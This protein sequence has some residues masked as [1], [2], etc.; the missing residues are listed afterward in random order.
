MPALLQD[1][2]HSTRM[3]I[4]NPGLSLICIITLGLGIS[5]PT[6]M[7]SIING[8]LYQPLPFEESKNLL[9]L[10]RNNPENNSSRMSV[11]YHDFVDWREQQRTLEDI[12]GSYSGTVNLNNE[13]E[14]PVRYQGAFITPGSFP[15]L[16]VDPVLGRTFAEDE[17][18]PDAPQVILLGYDVWQNRFGGESDA[19]GR[20]IRVNGATTTIIGVMPEGF[21]YP[22]D[23]EV[24][25]PIRYDP[26]TL[27]H[28]G[29]TQLQVFG[30]LKEEFTIEQVQAEFSGITAGLA[31][32]YPELN[33]NIGA[34]VM[35]YQDQFT[36]GET[37][38]ILYLL[39]VAVSSVL[40]IACFNVANVLLARAMTRTK[41]LA[42][43]ASLGA[44]RKRLVSQLLS[45]AMAI[46]F[47]GA[48]LG[49]LLGHIGITIFDNIVESTNPPFW[50]VFNIDLTVVLFVVALT[51]LSSIIS[52]ILPAIQ[53]TKTNI[54]EVLKEESRGASSFKM[55]RLSK[56]LVIG[57]VALSCAIL[58]VAGLLVKSLLTI[59]SFDGGFERENLLTARLGLFEADYPS[60]EVRFA[61]WKELHS[62]LEMIPGVRSAALTSH[63]PT[64]G[65]NSMTIRVSG[66]NYQDEE[67]YPI[68]RNI[69]VTRDFFKSM[70]MSVLQGRDFTNLDNM[71]G[72]RV[73]LVDRNFVDNVLQ[74]E[75]PL[76]MQIQNSSEPADRLGHTIVGVVSN[77]SLE[78]DDANPQIA[79]FPLYRNDSR[80]LSLMMKTEID[81]MSLAGNVRDAVA[82]IDGDLPIYWVISMKDRIYEETWGFRIFGGLLGI[83]GL[84]A[85]FL[86]SVGLYGVMTFSVNRRTHEIGI[87]LA[88]GAQPV[89]VTKMIMR[90]GAIQLL[91]GLVIGAILSLLFAPALRSLLFGV[92]PGDPSMLVII[93]VLLGAVGMIANLIPARR[94]TQIDPVSALRY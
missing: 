81:P 77:Q 13:G 40:F 71:E 48:L 75:N 59:N 83:A 84:A 17:V 92:E 87:R 65:S 73:C 72:E 18:K 6:L 52:G 7:F 57:E 91:I 54:N 34:N 56:V 49:L 11:T 50:F 53:S 74:G 15:L 36:T 38:T 94:A 14:R 62:K 39:L 8:A 90:Q 33:E 22:Q 46:S 44:T 43:R 20:E 55:V 51:I 35:R 80:F 60:E 24:W 63:M 27:E 16:R 41:E 45:E 4:K 30:R 78:P 76:G 28:G 23:Q 37:A 3:L 47:I 2:R 31:E 64:R 32:K 58:F 42:V 9:I 10:F 12:G 66:V 93:A 89:S 70:G 5:I 67:E 85:L 29:G 88:L 61:F 21:V 79:Y 25:M 69:I 1:F 68:T 26:L 19:V 86:A 82:S